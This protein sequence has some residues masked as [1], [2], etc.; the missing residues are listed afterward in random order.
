[1]EVTLAVGEVIGHMSVKSAA[2]TNSAVVL[3]V[4]TTEQANKL[5]ETSITV[6]GMFVLVFPAT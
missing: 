2:R 4:E 3:F 5:V 6:D 1:M